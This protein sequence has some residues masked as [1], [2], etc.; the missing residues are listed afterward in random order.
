MLKNMIPSLKTKDEKLFCKQ[1]YLTYALMEYSQNL[2]QGGTSLSSQLPSKLPM[3]ADPKTPASQLPGEQALVGQE[4]L[5]NSAD[6]PERYLTLINNDNTLNRTELPIAQLTE[7]YIQKEIG[8]LISL[9]FLKPTDIEILN[10]KI[11][12]N[13]VKGCGTT[14]GSYHM[15]QKTDGS[16]KKFTRI[17]LNINL[18]SSQQ[19]LA[20]FER[21]VRQIFIHE[22][23]HYLYYFKDSHTSVFD[24]FCRN[25][26]ANSC[27]TMDFVS[28]Y[29]SKNKEEDY[30]ESF[31]HWYL[32][33]TTESSMIVDQEHGSADISSKV[34]SA[35]DQYFDYTFTT[36]L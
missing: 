22:L 9:G 20:N 5:H 26:G 17:K 6:T 34:T 33:K 27:E 19:Y 30:A 14:R 25:K 32:E 24:K 21:Y 36:D 8:K 28:T 4:T 3:K 35:K 7:K 16:N 15:T 12:V 11:E 18:C 13:Y 10:E 1:K 2:Y 31:A 29:A 23:G